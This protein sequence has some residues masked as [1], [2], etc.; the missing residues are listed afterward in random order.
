MKIPLMNLYKQHLSLKKEIDNAIGSVIKRTDFISGKDIAKFELDFAS[1]IGAKRSLTVG[2][3]SVAL[4]LV[5]QALGIMP[6]DEVICPSFTFTA[7]AEAIVHAGANPVFVDIEVGG[8]NLDVKEVAKVITSK[9]KA[10]IPVHL[11]GTP[12]DMN[13]LLKLAKEYNLKIIEDAAQ[14]HGS[15]YH[16]KRIGSIGDAAIFSFFPAKN[17]GCYGDGG[18]ITT[19]DLELAEK[20]ARLKDHGRTSKYEHIEIG[21]GGRLDNIQAAILLAKLPSLEKW[22]ERRKE[23][24]TIYSDSLKELY[25]VPREYEGRSSVYYVYTLRH[26]KRDQI[27]EYLNKNGIATGIYYPKPLHLQTAYSYLGYNKGDLP[28]TEKTCQEIFSIPMYPE[29]TNDEVSYIIDNLK[30]FKNLK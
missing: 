18:A 10:I 23:I 6:G 2:S 14:A 1:Y 11:Y 20:L 16:G 29:L 7:T 26:P 4:D 30:R 28:R 27:I 13:P 8:Y 19:N 25:Q 9:T 15:I 24:A 17:L 12:A 22:N 3:G 5:I 21:Y